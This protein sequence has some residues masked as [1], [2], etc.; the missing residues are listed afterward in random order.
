[1]RLLLVNY[2]YPPVGGGAATATQQ[3]ARALRDLGHEP[4]VL[5]S[6]FG[7]LQGETRE[8]GIAVVRLNSRRNRADC[9]S[10][11]EMASFLLHALRNVARVSRRFRCEGVICFFSFPCGPIAWWNLQRTGAPYVV[12]LRGG[13]VPGT[14]PGL[15]RVHR[16]LTPLRRLTLRRARAVVANSAGLKRLSE[17]ADPIPVAVIPNGVD[18]AYF[19]PPTERATDR[20]HRFLFVG[21]FHEQKNVPWLLA[22][23]AGLQS[24]DWTLDLVGAGPQQAEI[25]RAADELRVTSRVRWHGWLPREQLRAIYQSADLIINPSRYEGMPNVLLEAMACGLPVLASHVAGNDAVV[26]PGET[27]ELFELGNDADFRARLDALLDSG[28]RTRLGAA[29]RRRV[30]REFAWAQTAKSYLELFQSPP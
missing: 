6:R 16:L 12:S 18:T 27:G 22:Q 1:M 19:A 13:D 30:E 28:Y 17:A 8:D 4:V 21:R 11:S 15:A 29:G 14:E 10:V 2:E 24:V 9:S 25:V 23:L 20:P 26:I 5:T 3:I 7:D